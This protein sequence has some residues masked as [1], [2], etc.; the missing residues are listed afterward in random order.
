[1]ATIDTKIGSLVFD[2]N[3]P[4]TVRIDKNGSEFS[5]ELKR[6][7]ANA[8]TGL[9]NK[10]IQLSKA[11]Y[12]SIGEF[13]ELVKHSQSVDGLD[14]PQNVKE[15]V[16]LFYLTHGDGEPTTSFTV[17]SANYNLRPLLGAEYTKLRLNTTLGQQW[18]DNDPLPASQFVTRDTRVTNFFQP[19]LVPH[20]HKLEDGADF[21]DALNKNFTSLFKEIQTGTLPLLKVAAVLKKDL[22]VLADEDKY[23]G[24]V[25]YLSLAPEDRMVN[26]IGG[27]NIVTAQRKRFISLSFVGVDNENLKALVGEGEEKLTLQVICPPDCPIYRPD[28]NP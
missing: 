3:S 24:V 19:L 13:R 18:P 10:E 1:M 11:L 4:T 12:L 16:L 2:E 20:S 6:L 8:S 25:I 5:S 17:I 21:V 7:M 15:E 23:A 27:N 14:E 22:R 26:V 9:K 28:E